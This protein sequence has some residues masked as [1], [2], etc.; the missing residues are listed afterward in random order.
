MTGIS[1]TFI[2]ST[3]EV[4]ERSFPTWH[5]AFKDINKDTEMEFKG[6]A[7]NDEQEIYRSMIGDKNE[8][9]PYAVRVMARLFN[10]MK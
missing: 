5:M 8:E 6:Y 10:K 2:I 7:S 9:Q 3:R 4:E 1:H